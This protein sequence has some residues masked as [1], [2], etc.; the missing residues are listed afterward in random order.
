VQGICDLVTIPGL[1]NLDLADVRTIMSGAGTAHMGIGKAHGE[2][3]GKKAAEMALNSSLLETSIDGAR[4]ILLNIS[5]GEEMSLHEI[6]EVAQTVSA[7][8]DPEANI[9]FG[10]VV[11]KT[12]GD[13]L[14]VTVVATGFD[15]TSEDTLTQQ[16]VDATSHDHIRAHVQERA[17]E[18]SQRSAPQVTRGAPPRVTRE[19]PESPRQTEPRP[20]DDD[21]DVPSFLR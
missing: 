19:A 15:A 16:L 14:W 12:L 18:V 5:G 11:D 3:R 8:A 9:I 2:G 1:I 21:L 7:A 10:A 4:G 13:T 20:S 17:R 6:T